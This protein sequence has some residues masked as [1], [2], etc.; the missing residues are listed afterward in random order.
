[1][2]SPVLNAKLIFMSSLHPFSAYHIM[3]IVALHYPMAARILRTSMETSEVT[4]R[5]PPWALSTSISFVVFP[6]FPFSLIVPLH[7]CLGVVCVSN[8][9]S[10]TRTEINQACSLLLRALETVGRVY[11]I[12]SSLS[13]IVFRI[14]SCWKC[15]E[16][17][18][19]GAGCHV[20]MNAC[21]YEQSLR[22]EKDLFL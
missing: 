10:L 20:W 3:R 14:L 7:P 13:W 6:S 17:E 12:V 15:V 21:L 8:N 11:F 19:T 5:V 1:M 2:T 16:I 18:T 4:M 22:N 9:V